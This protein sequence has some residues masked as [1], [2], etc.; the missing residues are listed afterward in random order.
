MQVL[1]DTHILLWAAAGSPRLPAAA[2]Q[3]LDD[4]RTE[5][6]FSAASIWEVVIKS[7][8]GRTD[9]TADPLQ[10]RRG[11]LRHGYAELP[12]TG[13]HALAVADLPTMH[14]DPFDRMLLAQARSEMVPLASADS[15]LMGLPDVLDL[16]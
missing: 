3:L 12:I 5:P 7:S 2:R 8:L 9:F 16:V 10:L 4:P 13:R 6:W 14:S 15:Q 1:L 11:L